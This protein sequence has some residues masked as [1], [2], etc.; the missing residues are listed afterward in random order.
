MNGIDVSQ[1]QGNIDFQKVKQAGIELVYMKASEG[2]DLVDPFFY[3]NYRKAIDVGLPVGFYHY[4][5]ARNVSSARQ[6]AYHFIAVTEGLDGAGKMVMDLE[7]LAGLT[8]TEINEIA[9]SFLRTIEEASNKDAAVYTDAYKASALLDKTLADY[10]LWIAQ[11]DV[12]TPDMDN[13]WG[14][15]AGWQYTD[16]GK[17]EGVQ[18]NTDRDI[19]KEGMLDRFVTVHQTR[20]RPPFGTTDI[21]YTVQPGD[22][23]YGIARKYHVTP[24][25]IARANQI[26]NPN[27]IYPG[28]RLSI[29]VRDDRR[30]A[31]TYL[32]YRVKPGDTFYAIASRF[33]TTVKKLTLENKLPDPNLIYPGQILKIPAF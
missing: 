29:P 14:D 13:P 33:G 25:E 28:Q 19:F 11:Y 30:Q 31:D 20:E 18:G 6:E 23:L 17:I 8:R 21:E 27:L 12:E 1:W 16:M 10:A 3:R 7:D 22:T 32:L 5:T 26:A 2:I 24:G 15:W 9:L 4:L